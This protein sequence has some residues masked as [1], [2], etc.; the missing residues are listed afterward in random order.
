M[1]FSQRAFMVL[2]FELIEEIL[3]RT[4][5]ESLIRFKTA[6]KRWYNLISRDK[7]FMYNHLDKSPERFL[8]IDGCEM[9]QIM[10]PATGI[11]S[12]TPIPH[13]FRDTYSIISMVHCDGLMLCICRGH[14]ANACLAVWNPVLRKFKWVKPSVRCWNSDYFGIG[15]D[16][17]SRDKY[18][19]LRFW[20]PL[21]HPNDDKSDPKF[22]IKESNSDSWRVLLGAEFDGE[23]DLDC[24]GVSVKG[25]MYWTA[26]NNN[27]DGFILSFD[28]SMETFKD[29]CLCPPESSVTRKLAC[30]D[31]DRLSLLQ[32]HYEE[33]SPEIEVWV[34]NKLSD[35][36]VSFHRYLSVTKPGAAALCFNMAITGYSVGKHRNIMAWCEGV[37]HKEDDGRNVCIKFYEIDEGR[38][39]KQIVTGRYRQI[40]YRGSLNTRSY[41]YVPS[42]V[43]IPGQRNKR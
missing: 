23:V 17:A 18:K 11:S 9:V 4:P 21:S 8:R 36:V 22:E 28:F 29:L 33:E 43:S 5:A 13:V 27:K 3:H 2:P 20:G 26:E 30:F 10:D 31:G 35:V 19:I 40:I 42:L 39:T 32:Q 16:N 37:D 14:R 24:R 1:I 25:N 6:C 12:V 38:I 7:K 34:T 41:V 15:Y